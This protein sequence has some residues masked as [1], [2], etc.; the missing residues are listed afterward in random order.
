MASIDDDSHGN[1]VPSGPRRATVLVI[2]DD[3][4]LP[5]RTRISLPDHLFNVQWAMTV[6][7]ANRLIGRDG[8][9]LAL[10]AI[11]RD[12]HSGWSFVERMKKISPDAPVVILA[13]SAAILDQERALR[14]GVDRALVKPISN[15]ALRRVVHELMKARNESWWPASLSDH[16][17][18]RL[19]ELLLDPT[20]GIPTIA[21]VMEE[22]R[23]LIE[24]GE[25]L[26]V[27]CI[28]IEPLFSLGERNLWDSFDVVRREFVRGLQLAAPAALGNDVVI[29]TSHPGANEFYCFAANPK[30]I[31]AA[32]TARAL[33]SEARS[34]LGRIHGD[35]WMIRE[36]AVFAGGAA[37]QQQP[38]YDP[39]ILYSAV[40][41]A[42]DIAERGET[43]Y[44]Q[45]LHDR[46][47]HALH[48]NSI[49]THFQPVVELNT[50]KV[51]GYEALSR[52]PA[53]TDLESPEIIFG[54]ARDFQVVWDIEKLCIRN[55]EPLL[56]DIC[57][58]GLLFFNLEST[59]IQE[60]Q[61]RGMDVLKPF[62]R[63]QN[64]VVIEVTERGAIRDFRLF[65]STLHEL[66]NLGFRI[67][68][69]DCG[70]SYSTLEAIAE[71]QPDFLKVGHALLQQIDRDAVRRRVVDLVA[72][73]GESIGAVTIAEAVETEEQLSVCRDLGIDMGQGFLFARPAPW[74]EV[75]S[76]S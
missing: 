71:L 60:L 70:S 8:V 19:R 26:H 74:A 54:L 64:R 32:G 35:P 75:R 68:I 31:S 67:A 43:R 21:W 18:G 33:E 55:I 3:P 24:R 76:H 52:G 30:R 73:C 2:D 25:P 56:D 48:D 50:R 27:Y 72:R 62:E 29:A 11:G 59:F 1:G 4:S 5:N 69:D 14:A 34:I 7:Q 10:V 53:G 65:R 23:E 41:E 17:N 45:G 15:D 57:E 49:V 36:I 66:K 6:A 37:T 12:D 51:I 28:E 63:C 44:F 39:R 47:L 58:S 40:R 9:D 38:V 61:E 16:G 46:L 20:T 22:L 13:E 42:K